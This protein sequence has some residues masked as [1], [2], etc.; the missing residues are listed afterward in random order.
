MT[1]ETVE[2][3]HDSGAKTSYDV[4]GKIT[5]Q[6]LMEPGCFYPVIELIR[7]SIPGC[8]H[9][10]TASVGHEVV[11]ELERNG[12]GTATKLKLGK[13]KPKQVFF[14]A[15]PSKV[16]HSYLTKMG[17]SAEWYGQQFCL[18]ILNGLR[19]EPQLAQ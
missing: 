8:N 15:L 5:R 11:Q 19:V 6:L 16:N 18:S 14:K 10:V 9:S 17:I 7:R 4:K 3:G 1:I 12:L 13:T 2:P